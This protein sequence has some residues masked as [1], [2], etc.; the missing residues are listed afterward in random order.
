MD[1]LK[2]PVR[3]KSWH[4]SQPNGTSLMKT[5][6]LF[7]LTCLLWAPDHKNIWN[8]KKKKSAFAK[9]HNLHFL[10][11][12]AHLDTLDS[13]IRVMWKRRCKFSCWNTIYHSLLQSPQAHVVRM[14]R[15][16]LTELAHSF[17]FCCCVY[18]CLYGSFNCVSFHSLFSHS[19]LPILSLSHRSF[20][21]YI[22]KWKSPSALIYL[23]LM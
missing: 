4:T 18:F 13:W 11:Y 15:H 14:L 17:L 22:S 16:K 10:C 8:W 5:K 12:C 1:K 9:K 21:L 7:W 23:A 6:V 19:D 3:N 20:N 2:L